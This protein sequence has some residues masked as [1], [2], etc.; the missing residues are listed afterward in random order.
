MIDLLERVALRFEREESS[1]LLPP[2]M[3]LAK[4]IG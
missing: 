1:L 4:T 2:V 3:K